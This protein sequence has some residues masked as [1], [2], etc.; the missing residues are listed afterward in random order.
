[1]ALTER[2]EVPG[3]SARLSGQISF[4]NRDWAGEDAEFI[5][6]DIRSWQREQEALQTLRQE[7][8]I[9]HLNKSRL[10]W[11]RTFA[12]LCLCSPQLDT[13]LQMRLEE[14]LIEEHA[15]EQQ[16]LTASSPSE[17]AV[18][19][20][21]A[22]RRLLR[23]VG[24]PGPRLGVPQWGILVPISGCPEGNTQR[25]SSAPE[26]SCRAG[27]SW[28]LQEGPDPEGFEVWMPECHPL[29]T[30]THEI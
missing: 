25:C 23:S 7:N 24:D 16:E 29:C 9:S 15:L 4:C 3:L 12:N 17:D 19:D 18:F 14:M 26:S 30:A 27:M 11:G 8:L 5:S 1:M 20:Q 22:R 2:H 21:R 10:G 6:F 13:R 28:G